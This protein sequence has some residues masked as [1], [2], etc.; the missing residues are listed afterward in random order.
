MTRFMNL[1]VLFLLIG[2]IYYAELL[3]LLSMAKYLCCK[4]LSGYFVMLIL[5]KAFDLQVSL[6]KDILIRWY[7]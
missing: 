1:V 4:S 7:F 5:F 6:R 3:V 2:Q